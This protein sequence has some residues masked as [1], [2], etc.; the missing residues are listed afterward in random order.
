MIRS[1]RSKIAAKVAKIEVT[2]D[3]QFSK[4]LRVPQVYQEEVRSLIYYDDAE[5]IKIDKFQTP[6]LLKL[7]FRFQ[8]ISKS[9]S[10]LFSS[11]I[12]PK[13]YLIFF[14]LTRPQLFEMKEKFLKQPVLKDFNS[15]FSFSE[16]VIDQSDIFIVK[17][18]V[19]FKYDYN[20]SYLPLSEISLLIN[21]PEIADYQKNIAEPIINDQLNK[22]PVPV[23]TDHLANLVPEIYNIELLNDAKLENIVVDS[24]NFDVKKL[25]LPIIVKIEVPGIDDILQSSASSYSVPLDALIKP[26]VEY[27]SPEIN[28]SSQIFKV[29]IDQTKTIVK[30]VVIKQKNFETKIIDVL[31]DEKI[32]SKRRENVRTLLSSYRELTW[33]E[34]SKSITGLELHQNEGAKFLTE[35]D[36]AIYG[37]ELGYDKFIQSL[38]ALNYLVKKGKVKSALIISDKNRFDA[39]WQIAFAD[40]GKG[41][42]LRSIDFDVHEKISGYS[43]AWFL[44]INNFAKIDINIF[45]QID[46]VILDEQINLKSSSNLLD[47][48]VEKIEPHYIWLLTAIVN[49][50]YNK[51]FLENFK[52]SSKVEFN[53]FGKSLSDI[54][55]DEPLVTY[56]D[57]WLELDE[58]QA[59]EYAE[60]LNQS[61]EELSKMID[62]PNPIR[63]QSNIFTFIH[64]LKQILNFSSFRNISPKANLLIEQA[65]AIYRNKKKAI[66]FTQYDA[67]GMKKIE[68]AFELNNIKFSVARNGMSTEELKNSL[69]AFYDHKEIPILLT[70]LKPARLK[71]K[72]DKISYIINF[73]QWW[74]P[75]TNWQ[76]DDEIGLNEIVNSPV[77]VFNYFIKNSIE[78]TLKKLLN[79][80]GLCNR[81]IFDNVKSETVSELILMED[82]L[83]VFGMNSQYNQNI[84]EERYKIQTWL[85]TVDLNDYKSL[86]KTFFTFLGY[87]DINIMDLANEPMFYIIGTARRGTAPVHL[88]GKCSLSSGLKI[89]DYEEVIHLKQS[90]NEI[91]RKFII[92]TGDFAEKVPNGTT[93]LDG[94]DLSNYILTLGINSLLIKKDL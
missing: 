68:K 34:Y 48:L 43:I 54:Q 18:A 11:L 40:Y 28:F 55:E 81:K 86:M 73:D 56:K 30:K 89:E 88:H 77:F 61:K 58:M 4:W 66:V 38:S 41:L 75:V 72:L 85:K 52:F 20:F 39:N 37:E 14:G 74:N 79:G 50:K 47:E 83:W 60:A 87:R 5:E 22:I 8:A 91:K 19:T 13:A 31:N 16:K 90:T 51:K 10:K 17:P 92:T 29:K 2:D 62:F 78:E 9:N 80:K 65:E 3:F 25:K 94:V 1:A 82:W 69:N 36:F 6:A 7:K 76:N 12:K 15:N 33:E 24:R 70:N 21:A 63:F 44:D 71:I 26:E 93:Y 53:Y 84:V 59:I 32:S 27:F 49:Q 64:K 45:S 57:F 35:N 46:L 42:E 23:I 67:N